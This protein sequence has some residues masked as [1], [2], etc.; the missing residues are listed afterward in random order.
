VPA[1]R[2]EET[3]HVFQHRLERLVMPPM[4]GT[5]PTLAT[6]TKPKCLTLHTKPDIHTEPMPIGAADLNSDVDRNHARLP[7]I[8]KMFRRLIENKT[9][10]NHRPRLFGLR[11]T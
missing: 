11:Q 6:R 3:R 10:D 1:P 9:L 8:G 5:P 7:G 2:F 4:L